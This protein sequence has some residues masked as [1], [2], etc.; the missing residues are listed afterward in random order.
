MEFEQLDE[1]FIRTMN[2]IGRHGWR[3]HGANSFQGRRL[4]GV[5]MRGPTPNDRLSKENNMRH[6][7]EHADAYLAGELH[8]HF[9][10]LKHQLAAIAFNAMMEYVCAD[11]A[12]KEAQLIE[13]R[14]ER[15]TCGIGDD[16]L[17]VSRHTVGCPM[18]IGAGANLEKGERIKPPIGAW[19]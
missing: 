1:S 11:L 18:R 8:D 15:C 2:E 14:K 3:K 7:K 10:T 16:L 13:T 6:V 19:E 12:S 9:Y 5:E 4:A 17:S